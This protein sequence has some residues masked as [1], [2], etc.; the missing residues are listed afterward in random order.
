MVRAVP[1][2]ALL[3]LALALVAAAA[4]GA[5]V[6]SGAAPA[7]SR[8]VVTAL[9]A[10]ARLSLVSTVTPRGPRARLVEVVRVSVCQSDSVCSDNPTFPGTLGVIEPLPQA[11]RWNVPLRCRR[12]SFLTSEGCDVLV[13]TMSAGCSVRAAV[14]VVLHVR[15]DP[16][17][18]FNRSCHHN[19][20][21]PP[22]RGVSR[23][24]RVRAQLVAGRR[25]QPQ[26]AMPPG[27]KLFRGSLALS[28]LCFCCDV[29]AYRQLV[30]ANKPGHPKGVRASCSVEL[31]SQPL[32]ERGQRRTPQTARSVAS[33][34]RAALSS[35]S[36]GTS[37]PDPGA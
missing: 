30:N 25:H 9:A 6:G 34:D 36:L 20:G 16:A 29:V 1:S 32:Q 11:Q 23:C 28:A 10:M 21:S 19:D 27:L 22:C 2:V 35:T 24:S 8:A 26:P 15:A 3:A 14:H 7:N 13:I 37:T 31:V 12:C 33:A 4:V 18:R 17:G 5:V